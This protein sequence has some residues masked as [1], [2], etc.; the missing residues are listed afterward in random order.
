ML[1]MLPTTAFA[2]WAVPTLTVEAVRDGDQIK[3]TVKI[4][5]IPTWA[6]SISR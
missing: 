5:P 2:A 6:R 4:G 3:A 1:T